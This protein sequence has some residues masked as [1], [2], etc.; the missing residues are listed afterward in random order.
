MGAAKVKLN[1]CRPGES[2]VGGAGF[3]ILV[4]VFRVLRCLFF[5]PLLAGTNSSSSVRFDSDQLLFLFPRTV[6]SANNLGRIED[7]HIYYREGRPL[8][9]LHPTYDPPPPTLQRNMVLATWGFPYH[10]PCKRVRLF[11]GEIF[12]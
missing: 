11:W 2:L 10:L 7:C 12:F 1:K 3:V 9:A 4:F 8:H 5:H 6:I